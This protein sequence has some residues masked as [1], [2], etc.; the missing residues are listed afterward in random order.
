[1]ATYTD[2]YTHKCTLTHS[3]MHTYAA[4][5]VHESHT[6]KHRW[7]LERDIAVGCQEWYRREAKATV[8]PDCHR[9]CCL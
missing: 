8:Q 3:D 9:S 4:V 6:T 5:K 2:Q 1:M 7:D